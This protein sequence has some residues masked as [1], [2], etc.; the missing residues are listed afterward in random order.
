MAGSLAAARSSFSENFLPGVVKKDLEC[1]VVRRVEV[2]AGDGP[3]PAG[4]MIDKHDVAGDEA[5]LTDN[6]RI[7]KTTR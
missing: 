1:I 7:A 2:W 4:D 3:L 5:D 6:G